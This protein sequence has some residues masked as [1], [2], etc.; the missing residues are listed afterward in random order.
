[1]FDLTEHSNTHVDSLRNHDDSSYPKEKQKSY[2]LLPLGLI[3][4]N[5]NEFLGLNDIRK[6]NIDK[7]SL[8]CTFSNLGFEWAFRSISIF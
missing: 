4:A 5:I 3:A 6:K 1:M 2:L 7:I 8:Y